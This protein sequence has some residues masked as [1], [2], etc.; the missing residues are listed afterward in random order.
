MNQLIQVLAFLPLPGV[1]MLDD[2]SFL[3]I[4]QLTDSQKVIE[5]SGDGSLFSQSFFYPETGTYEEYVHLFQEFQSALH[6]ESWEK[7]ASCFHYPLR[8]NTAESTVIVENRKE[9]LLQ[10]RQFLTSKT[11]QTILSSKPAQ[12]FSS[13]GAAMIAEGTV[14]ACKQEG[15]LKIFVINQ[16]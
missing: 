13:N 11:I 7:V 4:D 8:I 2:S 10:P 6:S 15:G 16:T 3:K 12:V 9:F 1:V 5:I 14:W